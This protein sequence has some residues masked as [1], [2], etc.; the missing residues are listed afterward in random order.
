VSSLLESAR[1]PALVA[2]LLV[3]AGL[4][5]VG[6][7]VLFAG[8]P[9]AWLL[10]AVC[11]AVTL[12]VLVWALWERRYFEP[13]PV[14][15]GAGLLL[16][17]LRP[18]QLFTSTEDLFS[19]FHS[20]SSLDHLVNLENQEVARFVTMELDVSLES[21][22]ARATGACALFLVLFVLGYSLGWGERAATWLSRRGRRG[23]T[24]DV[25]FAVVASLAIGIAA[26]MA[27]IARAG[28][29]AESLSKAADQE[30]LGGSLALNVLTG[31]AVA[32][33][34]VWAAWRRPRSRIEWA[35]FG[36]C[37]LQLLAYAIIVGS[38]ARVV[39][40]LIMLVVMI[41]YLWRPWRLREIAGA[42]VVL[43]V[44]AGLSLAVREGA[45]RESLGAAV[46]DSPR[47]ALDVRGVM[48]DSNVYDHVLFATQLRPDPLPYKNGK[49]LL[50][51]VHSYV[52]GFIDASKPEGGDIIFRKEVW[53]DEYRAG[54]PP[55]IVG[56]LYNDFGF[57]GIAIGA[58]LLG[59][60]ARVLLG[61]LRN[62]TARGREYRVVLYAL[63]VVLLY[64]FITS[65]YSVALGLGLTFGLPLAVAVHG[66][67]RGL[68]RRGRATFAPERAR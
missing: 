37:V 54:R 42:L 27:M 55:T 16:F 60:I 41:H 14:I 39:L 56:D 43:V 62:P 25:R 7:L 63:S 9:V 20:S 58:V 33:L 48:S 31:F 57:A 8:L 68:P 3:G 1:G 38:R 24:I 17:V 15:A 13:L 53:G 36:L 67:G 19:Y 51:A 35:G 21:A 23:R 47:Y 66:L 4:A 46:A 28:G 22:L 26:E 59:T 10:L 45:E 11:A 44:L 2:V 32:G 6:S 12:P 52:P 29:P 50:D 61:F 34:L 18:L 65:T 40:P 49:V 30:A 5:V 64:V